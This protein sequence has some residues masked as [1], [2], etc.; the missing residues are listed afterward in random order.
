[1]SSLTLK[2]LVGAGA[3][4]TETAQGLCQQRRK[5]IVNGT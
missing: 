5:G 2:D 3:P 1:M 4:P